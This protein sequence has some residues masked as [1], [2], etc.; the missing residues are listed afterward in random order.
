MSCRSIFLIFRHCSSRSHT[1]TDSNLGFRSSTSSTTKNLYKH[2]LCAQSATMV[3]TD[4]DSIGESLDT[5]AGHGAN[6]HASH[7]NSHESTFAR[8]PAETRTHLHPSPIPSTRFAHPPLLIRQTLVAHS[9]SGNAA[10]AAAPSRILPVTVTAV[11]TQSPLV[12]SAVQLVTLLAVVMALTSRTSMKTHSRV[13][14]SLQ[15]V[16]LSNIPLSCITTQIRL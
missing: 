14:P 8:A 5:A 11:K 9:P 4:W 13:S 10:E 12:V 16:R 15:S 3:Y 1:T 6:A 7:H 2:L